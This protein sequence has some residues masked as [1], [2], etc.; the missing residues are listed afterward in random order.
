LQ[1]PHVKPH[2]H[3]GGLLSADRLKAFAMIDNSRDLSTNW[4]LDQGGE[5]MT[6]KKV[7][8]IQDE[9]PQDKTIRPNWKFPVQ[10]ER[11]DDPPR[12]RSS[13]T[14]PRKH[15]A[16]SHHRHHSRAKSTAGNQFQLPPR[17]DVLYREQSVEDYSDLFDDNDAIL[18]QR[19]S[20]KKV[21]S[22]PLLFV[23]LA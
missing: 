2:D 23:L 15:S 7:Q 11:N 14:S 13:R 6:M 16:S 8:P 17:P 22:F 4:D 20:L 3:F 5:L 1:L 21:R 9:D 19:L 10:L 12:P 18:N